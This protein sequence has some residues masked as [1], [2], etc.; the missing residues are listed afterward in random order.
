[1]VIKN[2]KGILRIIEAVIALLIIFGAL[3]VVASQ[4]KAQTSTD[5]S[6]GIP[7]L[8]EEIARNDTLRNEIITAGESGGKSVSAVEKDLNDSFLAQRVLNP[9]IGHAIQICTPP[10]Q[11]CP[12]KNVDYNKVSGEVYTDDRIISSTVLH[13]SPKRI[14]IFLW[15]KKV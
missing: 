6:T 2:K 13:Y 7:A 11:V 5:L 9:S 12:L 4:R 10:D 1:M 14:K 15:I 8:L 3:L